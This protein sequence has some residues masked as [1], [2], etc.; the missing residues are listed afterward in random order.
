[1]FFLAA[2]IA[3]AV[4]AAKFL[5]EFGFGYGGGFVDGFS[6]RS[7]FKAMSETRFI[8]DVIAAVSPYF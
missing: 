3:L 6:V 4:D 7:V 8:L 1:M 5:E 2:F